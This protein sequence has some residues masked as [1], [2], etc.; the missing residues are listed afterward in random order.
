MTERTIRTLHEQGHKRKFLVLVD[1]SPE[2][3]SSV[4]FSACRA[5]NT[6]S[7][8]LMLFVI[9]PEEFQHWISVGDIQREEGEKKAA[10]V[11][12][13]YGRKLKTW[14]FDDLNVEEVARHG[15]VTEQIEAMINEDQDVAFFV[16]GASMSQHGPGR[17]ISWLAGQ[18]SGS[19]PVPI[20]L[21]PQTLT[22]EE[23]NALA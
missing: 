5:N 2:C 19:F 22:H 8:L 9:E 11:F 12:R 20:V 23:I 6:N 13:L 1:E 21:V 14:G 3:E 16:L 17:L 7:D 18:A 10:A 15:E 4:Y